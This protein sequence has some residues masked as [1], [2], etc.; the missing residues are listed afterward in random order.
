LKSAGP[1]GPGFYF[2]SIPDG[3]SVK[4]KPPGA[5]NCDWRC[6]L[7]FFETQ[8][9]GCG[10]VVGCE[11][12][13]LLFFLPTPS[14][15]SR[16]LQRFPR[17]AKALNILRRGERVEQGAEAA[18]HYTFAERIAAIEKEGLR[19]DSYTTPNGSLSPLQ[20][21]IDLAL[22]PN[23]GLRNALVRIDLAGLRGAGYNIPRVTRIGRG[24]NM[25]GG[26]F[27]MVFKYRIPPKYIEVI[28]R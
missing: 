25:P 12:Q 20:A 3:G 22:S 11:V 4:L 26:D 13:G 5:D 21:Q 24:F 14:K 2:S 9:L 28:R 18:Y 17:L 27:E 1:K 23:Q 16:L 7:G 6:G 8:V 19:A 10:S 15:G